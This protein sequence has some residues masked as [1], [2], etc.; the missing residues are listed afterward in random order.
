[1]PPPLPSIP[2]FSTPFAR[3]AE[4]SSTSQSPTTP[5]S[6]KPRNKLSLVARQR[7][8]TSG[9]GTGPFG[10]T[11]RSISAIETSQLLPTPMEVFTYT[12][13]KDHDGHTFVY[14]RAVDVNPPSSPL[15]PDTA[16]D[17]LVTP[18]DTTA[19]PID[20][21]LDCLEDRHHRFDSDHFSYL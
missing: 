21:T 3:P 11:G 19:H 5:A 15:H 10:H 14:R 1:M 20:T 13:T 8:E 9:D 17:T 4:F 18:T 12:H 16:D 2:S 7:S 6:S